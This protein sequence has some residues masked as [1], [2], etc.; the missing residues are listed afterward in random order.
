MSTVDN[1]TPKKAVGCWI[2]HLKWHIITTGSKVRLQPSPFPEVPTKR[3][4]PL[5]LF[6]PSW[7]RYWASWFDWPL[8]QLNGLSHEPKLQQS[9]DVST[10][11]KTF[12]KVLVGVQWYSV[13]FFQ[14]QLR[15]GSSPHRIFQR[16]PEFM[17][18]RGCHQV[19]LLLFNVFL[20]KLGNL[21]VMSWQFHVDTFQERGGC[22]LRASP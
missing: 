9:E 19:N 7:A 2:G 4:M 22:P 11:V 14:P 5:H 20:R 8:S 13:L 21:E 18:I 10:T 15:F 6:T 16:F 12:K 1:W 17:F 3:Q